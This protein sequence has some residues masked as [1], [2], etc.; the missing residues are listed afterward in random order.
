M[1]SM[2][3]L[4]DVLTHLIFTD[5]VLLAAGRL[6]SA[7]LGPQEYQEIKQHV[8]DVG[9]GPNGSEEAAAEHVQC[10]N[11]DCIHWKPRFIQ[12]Q[13]VYFGDDWKGHEAKWRRPHTTPLKNLRVAFFYK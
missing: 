11:G 8:R 9:L 1:V 6:R 5:P 10:A 7:A 12:G 2:H 3:W 4:E 13:F